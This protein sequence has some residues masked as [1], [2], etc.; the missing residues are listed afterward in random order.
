MAVLTSA[1]V[2]LFGCLAEKSKLTVG[3]PFVVT[4]IDTMFEG[5]R[6]KEGSVLD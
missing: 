6:V 2:T 5:G 3:F 4:V 1:I